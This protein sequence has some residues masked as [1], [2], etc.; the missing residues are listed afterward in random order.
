MTITQRALDAAAATG[1]IGHEAEGL[2]AAPGLRAGQTVSD[3]RHIVAGTAR[4]RRAGL[5]EAEPGAGSAGRCAA[6][7]RRLIK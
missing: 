7:R 5:S 3:Q 6:Q 1:R 4:A 2:R